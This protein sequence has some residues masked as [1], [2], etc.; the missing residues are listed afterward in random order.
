MQPKRKDEPVKQTPVT[1]G[2]G[3][4]L[5]TSQPVVTPIK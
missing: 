2:S 3:T 4:P 1:S 5:T